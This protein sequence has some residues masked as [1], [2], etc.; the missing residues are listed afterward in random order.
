VPYFWQFESEEENRRRRLEDFHTGLKT[1]RTEAE[2]KAMTPWEA[3]KKPAEPTP[4][5][6]PLQLLEEQYGG[7]LPE[8]PETA[9]PLGIRAAQWAMTPL[10]P[11]LPQ[12]VKETPV[13]G[14]GAEFLRGFTSPVGIAST[15]AWPA[16]T[17]R[18]A[19]GGLA[20][21]TAGRAAEQ[22][23]APQAQ[24]GGTRVGPGAVG[25]TVGML[26]YPLVGPTVEKLALNATGKLGAAAFRRAAARIPELRGILAEEAGGL[27][28]RVPE[29]AAPRPAAEI[30]AD[31]T[32][33]RSITP[34]GALAEATQKRI[35]E[36]ETELGQAKGITQETVPEVTAAPPT[37]A[38]RPTQRELDEAMLQGA[39]PPEPPK[40]PTAEAAAGGRGAVPERG[41]S[42]AQEII[43]TKEQSLLKPGKV[44]Q[45]PVVRRALGVLNPS[46]SAER[47]VTVAYT[48]RGAATASLETTWNASRQPIV[49][50]LE[51]AWK[52]AP[53][54][55]VGP[56]ERSANLKD[57]LFDFA[58][59]PQ[60]YMDVSP[61]LTEAVKAINAHQDTVLAEARGK[62][63][64]DIK[65]YQVKPGGFFMPNVASRESLEAA[66][67][68]VASSYTSASTSSKFGT[69]RTRVYESAA[70][71]MSHDASFVPETDV[72][73]LL[74]LHDAA[75]ARMAGNE[76]F[77]LGVGG[78]NLLEVMQE[79]HPKLAQ[80]MTALRTRLQGLRGTAGRLNSKLDM[81]VS[82]FLEKPDEMSLADLADSLDVKITRGV[83][84]GMDMKAINAEIRAVRQEIRNL[85]PAWEGANLDPY[86]MNRKTYRYYT[87]EQSAAI[88][89]ILTTRLP[90]GQTLLDAIDEV[91]VTAFGGDISPLTIQMLLG[92]AADPV[93]LARNARGIVRELRTGTRMAE[94][95]RE[96]PDL[97]QRFVVATG[98]KFGEMGPEFR[99]V[100]RGPERIPGVG[101]LWAL[102]N[103]RTMQAVE[104]LRYQ[105]WK[106]D[107]GLLQKLNP[108]MSQAVADAEAANT[109]SKIMPA[110]NPAE[111]GA[112]VLQAKL[113]RAPVISTSFL[114]GPAALLK[115]A[116]S[117]FA[118]L[119]TSR[120]LSVAARWQG[121]AG[122]EQLAVLRLTA[123][124]GSL[125]SL[126]TVSYIASGY[127]PEEAAKAVL[128]PAGGRFLSLA[129]GKA[130]YIPI[131]GPF[132]SFLR[133]L[134]PRYVNGKLVPFAGALQFL[135]GK[136]TPSLAT[137]T[138]LI[139]NKDFL[140]RAIVQG[141]FPKNLLSGLW[142]AAERHTPLTGAAVSEK[143]RTGEVKPG[144]VGTLAREAGTQLMGVNFYETSPY[145]RRNEARDAAAQ[146][147]FPGKNWADLLQGEQN[148]VREANP[149]L[150]Q[151]ETEATKLG[152]ER[153]SEYSQR[154]EAYRA[155][156]STLA[157]EGERLLQSDPTGKDW[158]GWR[159]TAGIQLNTAWDMLTTQYGIKEEPREPK[160]VEDQLAERYWNLEPDA[161][162]DGIISNQ[163]WAAYDTQQK[164]IL[165][166][167]RASGVSEDYIKHGYRGKMWPDNPQL[168]AIEE[169]Y[170]Q[171]KE[172]AGEYND[173]PYKARM[174]G[175]L[176]DQ[177]R[178]YVNQAQSIASLQGISFRSA[179][180]QLGIAADLVGLAL[181]YKELP[182]NPARAAF[183]RQYPEKKAVYYQFYRDMP[184]NVEAEPEMALAGAR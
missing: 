148:Q 94:I 144:E 128:N 127:S 172:I 25:E 26:G 51:A 153:G 169:Q 176:Q 121:L 112:S 137:A 21:G 155:Q 107:T 97:V 55:Y 96:E 129:T 48:G 42:G 64:V 171:A 132:R 67:E 123:M 20:L 177:V 74:D 173:I 7:K 167:A 29:G 2:R 79:T 161:N 157:E 60:D 73:T 63:G 80:R 101:K 58:Q 98:R 62:Y 93:T 31:L 90:V 174:P 61:R 86:V 13:L 39:K 170:Q 30:E 162:N 140:G 158:V 12:A 11:E 71:R 22:A 104:Y 110:L 131:G 76:T 56:A 84:A 46:V 147:M 68:K 142:Y 178:D 87:P 57:T 40:P 149:S 175:E 135:R 181:R 91:R 141:D 43:N 77:K 37:E 154:T 108:G 59:N 44:T 32:R 83:R 130:G 85:R 126:S 18:M 180:M 99:Q 81:A 152:A 150:R 165:D 133:A 120:E 49:T 134:A 47:N 69:A 100:S 111:R 117:G 10:A 159:K 82:S 103:D 14:P 16:V 146:Q 143:L 28:P 1:L 9:T 19:A 6:M 34:R 106:N 115:D 145:D 4:P 35:G 33:L 15:V 50:E 156:K 109:W 66:G 78:K 184:L 151:L 8:R 54:R 75:V 36:L 163:E 166:E 38:Y 125:A 88:D 183:W 92:S 89:K 164:G 52:E 24:V 182:I 41:Y 179:L 3:A 72:S 95:A 119:G 118:K 138:D 5:K 136:E 105:A 122:R 53:A 139:R 124:G 45:I 17:A 27:K 23:G 168:Q 65:P 116:A 102:V 113:E 160:F 70:Q 114:G